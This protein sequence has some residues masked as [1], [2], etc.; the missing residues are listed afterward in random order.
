MDAIKL[1]GAPRFLRTDCGTENGTAAAIQ[2]FMHQS[3]SSHL[4]GKS[5]ANQRI[6]ALWEKVK[7][8]LQ[9]WQDFFLHISETVYDSTD[10]FHVKALRFAFNNLLQLTLNEFQLYWNNHHVRRSSDAPGGIPDV[11]FYSDRT[12]YTLVPEPA[13]LQEVMDDCAI[14]TVCGAEDVDNYFR[15]IINHLNIP[16]PQTKNEALD[17]FNKFIQFGS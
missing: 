8:C 14:P 9:Q 13:V 15:Y 11:L 6:E 5:T 4:Y 17:L 10:E 16:T 1:W 7:P 2:S 3:S 12:T